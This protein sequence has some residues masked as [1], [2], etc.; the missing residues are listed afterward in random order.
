M[1]G[2]PRPCNVTWTIQN[3]DFEVPPY[4]RI[5]LVG[6]VFFFLVIRLCV[7]LFYFFSGSFGRFWKNLFL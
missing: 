6:F 2:R 1:G 5:I 3:K 4:E 7:I